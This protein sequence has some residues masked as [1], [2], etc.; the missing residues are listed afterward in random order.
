PPPTPSPLS[1]H[2]ALPICPLRLVDVV[3]PRDRA[4]AEALHAELLDD[5]AVDPPDARVALGRIA[6]PD[7]GVGDEGADA[8]GMSRCERERDVDRKSTRLNSS[9]VS[10]SY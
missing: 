3:E 8:A 6:C 9:H 5:R 10:I 7:V 2:D 4:R 1:L